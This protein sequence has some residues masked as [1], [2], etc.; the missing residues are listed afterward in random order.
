MEKKAQKSKVVKKI[1]SL[2]SIFELDTN[3]D[4][5]VVL[6]VK[7]G[8]RMDLIRC[9]YFTGNE[10]IVLIRKGDPVEVA[11]FY[12]NGDIE[13]GKN[14]PNDLWLPVLRARNSIVEFVERDLKIPCLI[15][16]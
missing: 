5:C 12:K 4:V 16:Q 10:E 14:K 1:P 9:G 6:K 7:A 2:K 8:K 11:F 15:E 13:D 3:N